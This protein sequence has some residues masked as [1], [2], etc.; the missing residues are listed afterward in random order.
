ML[1]DMRGEDN[2]QRAVVKVDLEDL[3]NQG[4]MTLPQEIVFVDEALVNLTRDR[5][6]VAR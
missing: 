6:R 4:G 2:N 1:V 5:E 3:L